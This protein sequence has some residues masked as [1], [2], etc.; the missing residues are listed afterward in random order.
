M[1]APV[2]ALLV[3]VAVLAFVPGWSGE[4]R[5]DLFDRPFR[6]YAKRVP[7]DPANPA[8]SRVGRLTFL[9]GVALAAGDPAFGGYSALAVEGDRFTLLSDGGTVLRFRMGTDWRPREATYANL[10]TGPSIGWQKQDRDS[11]SLAIDP[12]TGRAWVGFERWNTIGRYAPGLAR[13]E[14]LAMPR[15]MDAWPDNGGP[16][17]MVRLRDGRFMVISESGRPKGG[18]RGGRD[19]LV[20][21][22]DPTVRTRPA[23][24]FVYRPP[25]H[26]D[27]SDVTELPDGRLLVLNRRFRLP[28]VW[29]VK[30]T[31][32]E[33]G[34]MRPGRQAIGREIATIAPP[35]TSDNYEGVAVTREGNATIVWL[36]SDDNQSML[37]RTLLMKFRL[38]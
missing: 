29:S 10:P 8:R 9:G 38:S 4:K 33:R 25:R 16:E 15:A 14:R 24:R 26:Y 11:E 19:A 34:A 21:A 22:G 36:V 28:F 13:G 32:V 37:E 12:T 31:I 7:L 23:F 2:T 5:L 6:L 18:P 1:R 17:A 35:L 27:P 20:F 3:V 30:L